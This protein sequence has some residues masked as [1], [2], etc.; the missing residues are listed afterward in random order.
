M[1]FYGGHITRGS[2][3]LRRTQ[4]Y[5]YSRQ[6]NSYTMQN[7]SLQYT[8]VIH[9]CMKHI[10]KVY[11][12][13]TQWSIHI[14]LDHTWIV[15]M[16]FFPASLYH[17]LKVVYLLFYPFINHTNTWIIC[18]KNLHFFSSSRQGGWRS[19]LTPTKNY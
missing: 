8:L 1:I 4:F 18:E 7:N 5:F 12:H 11:G 17:F 15:L 16:R 19:L 9:F 14:L 13:W 6:N 10:K 2:F 3:L